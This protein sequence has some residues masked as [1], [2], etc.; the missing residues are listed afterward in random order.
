VPTPKTEARHFPMCRQIGHG[1]CNG[2]TENFA[3][4][5]LVCE[6]RLFNI[7]GRIFSLMNRWREP[8]RPR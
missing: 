8:D 7:G 6:V 5:L 1:D 4:S 2:A 3:D